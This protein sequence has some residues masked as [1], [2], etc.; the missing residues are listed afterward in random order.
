[1]ARITNDSKLPKREPLNK[2]KYGEKTLKELFDI[3]K[4]GKPFPVKDYDIR[5]TTIKEYDFSNCVFDQL[6]FYNVVFENCD[7][8][9]CSFIGC[10]F[11]LCTFKS[12]SFWPCNFYQ[13]RFNACKFNNY[14][15]IKDSTITSSVFHDCSFC[16]FKFAG[17]D[18][19]RTFVKNSKHWK[20]NIYGCVFV[21]SS[22]TNMSMSSFSIKGSLRLLIGVKPN[23][24]DRCKFIEATNIPY[25]PSRCPEEGEFIGYKKVCS[26]IKNR[27]LAEELVAV[28]LIPS[29][30]KRI[31]A[32][33]N[34]SRFSKCRC[35]KAKVLR[36]E[37]L[38]GEPYD[39]IEAESMYASNNDAPIEKYVVGETVYPDSFD[40]NRDTECSHGI[41]FFMTREEAVQY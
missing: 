29:D 6:Y 25:V 20:A 9:K 24:F 10:Q 22:F 15:E 13:T 4:M 8:Y 36:L 33:T 23:D 26:S 16:N 32:Y 28:L 7:F 19:N 17:N 18:V 1:M 21:N 39:G 14:S 2:L 11:K 5:N 40:S 41:H 30:A 37:H 35:S 3:A 34:D 38:D 31:S 12:V 27:F